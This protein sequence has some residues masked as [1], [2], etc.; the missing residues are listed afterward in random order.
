LFC[1]YV[2]TSRKYRDSLKLFDELKFD[3]LFKISKSADE[4][5]TTI[6][7]R[8][9]Y[10]KYFLNR[11]A[12]LETSVQ[13]KHIHYQPKNEFLSGDKDIDSILPLISF[14]D[15]YRGGETEAKVY[16]G[17]DFIDVSRTI[18]GIGLDEE[19]A[20]GFPWL[21]ED[22]LGGTA[23][24]GGIELDNK[25][26]KNFGFNLYFRSHLMEDLDA[27][28]R[29][30]RNNHAGAGVYY[31]R[32]DGMRISALYEHGWINDGN[33]R[34][35]FITEIFYPLYASH[36][37]YDYRGCRVDYLHHPQNTRIDI[38]YKLE[39]INDKMKS[40]Y[41]EN[42]Y[43]EFRHTLALYLSQKIYGNLFFKLEGYGGIGTTLDYLAGGKAGLY[44]E[45]PD[46][47]NRFGFYIFS[48]F[49][50]TTPEPEPGFETIS[51]WSRTNGGM[52][53]IV[54]CF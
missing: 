39:Y 51:G 53:N 54:W 33:H 15:R 12:D 27:Y 42:Y 5:E 11:N 2:K 9:A 16:A 44:Y 28:V 48:E 23:F 50:K 7:G 14:R 36:T 18:I 49:D 22:D 24:I 13:Y 17:A 32:T 26:Y 10:H 1:E 30:I 45:N 38:S 31:F 19:D 37:I 3:S 6:L 21:T 43:D 34:N 25:F 46:T 20:A 41:Y 52:F 8:L 29:L 40:L 4:K 47:H 35:R